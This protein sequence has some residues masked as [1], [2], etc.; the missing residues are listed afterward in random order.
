MFLS[1]SSFCFEE[2]SPISQLSK[3]NSAAISLQQNSPSQSISKGP[4]AFKMSF[5]QHKT[6]PK[7]KSRIRKSKKRC[8]ENVI[9]KEFDF[10]EVDKEEY[11]E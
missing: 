1:N 4:V 9:C 3:E 2:S 8:V 7:L 6:F 10:K 11:I 5:S